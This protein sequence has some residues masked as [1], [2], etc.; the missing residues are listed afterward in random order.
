MNLSLGK[1][2]KLKSRKAI[3]RLFTN[4]KQLKTFPVRAIYFSELKEPFG[5]QI[6]VSVP[7]RL[8][9]KAVD[10]NLLKRRLREAFRKNQNL[11]QSNS[12]IEIMFIYTSSEI[13]TYQTIEK[14]MITLLVDLNSLLN[15]NISVK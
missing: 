8:F 15:D 1:N 11:L 2:K 14:S 7:K 10:R 6:A 4:G 3:E 9:K 13:Q 5:T 12:Q